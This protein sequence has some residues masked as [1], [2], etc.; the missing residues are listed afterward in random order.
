M[1]YHELEDIL[2]Y[3][4]DMEIPINSYMTS[5]LKTIWLKRRT[6]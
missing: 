4:N 1:G 5:N 3:N 2:F 6:I